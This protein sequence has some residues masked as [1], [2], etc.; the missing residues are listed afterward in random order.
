M[1]VRVFGPQAVSLDRHVPRGELILIIQQD[2]NLS[3]KALQK[4]EQKEH[5]VLLT[6]RAQLQH[7]SKEL[8]GLPR[9]QRLQL[10]QL[11]YPLKVG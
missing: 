11:L 1:L 5:V 7:L 9:P 6:A 10:E 3:G 8:R 2:P 4:Q